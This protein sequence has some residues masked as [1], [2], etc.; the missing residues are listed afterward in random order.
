MS[1]DARR[2]GGRRRRRRPKDR[3]PAP[4]AAPPPPEAAEPSG[5]GKRPEKDRRRGRRRE[6][7]GGGRGGREREARLQYK[8][9]MTIPE[10]EA[11]SCPLCGK[12]VRDPV[13]ALAY[14]EDRVPAH[15]DCVLEALRGGRQLAADERM[16]YLGGGHFGVVRFAHG[17]GTAPFSIRERTQYESGQERP[18]WRQELDSVRRR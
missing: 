14:G 9:V 16:C 10:A 2:A 4:A 18:P 13:A 6:G 12:K 11:L 3:R 15:F 5:G 1:D 8:S 7:Q 17:D